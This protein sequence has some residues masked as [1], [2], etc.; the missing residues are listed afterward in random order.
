MKNEE[1]AL[2]DLDPKIKDVLILF[3]LSNEYYEL[4]VK[5]RAKKAFKFNYKNK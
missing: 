2:K 1:I 3:V 4:L 5:E